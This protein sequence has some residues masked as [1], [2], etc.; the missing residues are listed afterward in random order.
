MDLETSQLLRRLTEL[1]EENNKILLKVQ[2]HTRWAMFFS[3]LKWSLFIALTVGSYLAVQPYIG[4]AIDAYKSL[5]SAK[6]Q[7]QGIQ[8]YLKNIQNPVKYVPPT[9]GS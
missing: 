1:T 7:S 9:V 8:D 5:E 3:F 6:S 4:E 2:K